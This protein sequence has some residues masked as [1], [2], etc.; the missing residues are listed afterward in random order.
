MGAINKA[1]ALFG[2]KKTTENVLKI[3]HKV[4]EALDEVAEHHVR[5]ADRHDEI[6]S[7]AIEAHRAASAE[8]EKARAV[9][10]KLAGLLN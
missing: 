5:E 2:F 9:R 6:A 4:L 1:L 10:A 8:A 3:F 7:K